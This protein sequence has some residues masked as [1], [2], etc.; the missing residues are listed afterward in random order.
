MKVK[1]VSAAVCEEFKLS[2]IHKTKRVGSDEANPDQIS[3]EQFR[4]EQ[5]I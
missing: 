3:E 5:Q 1:H 4:I 2:E